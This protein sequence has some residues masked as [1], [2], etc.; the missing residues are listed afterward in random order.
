[1]FWLWVAVVLAAL[2]ALIAWSSRR[3]KRIHGDSA[4]RSGGPL[5]SSDSGNARVQ[6]EAGHQANR[7]D[8]QAMG[9]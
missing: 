5:G 2:L 9:G 3:A 8:Q 4:V 6:F 1:M 7:G